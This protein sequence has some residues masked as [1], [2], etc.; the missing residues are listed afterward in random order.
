MIRQCISLFWCRDR[1]TLSGSRIWISLECTSTQQHNS[2]SPMF[3]HHT[4]IAIELFLL[5]SSNKCD[6]EAVSAWKWVEQLYLRNDTILTVLCSLYTKIKRNPL[7]SHRGVTLLHIQW[8]PS[9]LE[10]ATMRN[11]WCV[12]AG[13]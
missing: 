7:S 13:S 9:V 3:I 12:A 5:G 6:A 4:V 11:C 2:A 1:K 10:A 8:Y